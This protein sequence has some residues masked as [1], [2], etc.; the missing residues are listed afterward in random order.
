MA[1]MHTGGYQPQNFAS[2]AP[3][4]PTLTGPA[5][6]YQSQMTGLNS[7]NSSAPSSATKQEIFLKIFSILIPTL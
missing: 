4:K 2:M 7:M 6:S 5:G 3:I 1:P